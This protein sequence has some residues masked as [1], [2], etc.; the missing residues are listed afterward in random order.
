MTINTSQ[1]L[2]NSCMTSTSWCRTKKNRVVQICHKSAQTLQWNNRIV[3]ATIVAIEITGSNG[4]SQVKPLK[5]EEN[6]TCISIY[7]A[8]IYTHTRLGQMSWFVFLG[9][10]SSISIWAWFKSSVQGADFLAYRQANQ[11][12][13][14]S[15]HS[16]IY[17]VSL[18]S[19]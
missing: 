7:I 9:G 8:Y 15:R 19:S 14:F 13:Y 17:E 5:R 4:R 18:L 11:T 16:V 2:L 3:I 6:R 12:L 10:P 1:L